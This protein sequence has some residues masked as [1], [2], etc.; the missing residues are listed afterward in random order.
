MTKMR[1]M[2]ALSLCLSWLFGSP[3]PA[4]DEVAP[5]PSADLDQ[6]L[7]RLEEGVSGMHTLKTDFIQRKYLAV[8]KRPLVLKGTICMEKPDLFS[9]IVREPLRYSLVVRGDVIHQW[10]EDTQ[11]VEK[12]SLAKNPVFKMAIQQ[13]RDWLS[14]AYRSMLGEYSVTVVRVDPISLEF[15]P[16][17]TAMAREVI[18]RVTVEFDRDQHYIRRIEIFEKRGDRTDLTFENTVLNA[19]IPPTAWKARQDVR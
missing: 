10:D 5:H 13:L 4:A 18:D 8:L 14:G 6:I 3:S 17:E 1:R 12:I 9:W 16:R 19:P 7:A 2:L 15:V 11:R